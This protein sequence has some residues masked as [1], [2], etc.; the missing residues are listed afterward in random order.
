MRQTPAV[1]AFPVRASDSCMWYGVPQVAVI[2]KPGWL[3]GVCVNTG[4]IPS[5][6]FREAVL[7]L[8]GD[9]HTSATPSCSS[10]CRSHPMPRQPTTPFS[11]VMRTRLRIY[12]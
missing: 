2:D 9:A 11:P 10:L 7:H 1:S 5:K 12:T 6:T 4:T 8:T 3:G